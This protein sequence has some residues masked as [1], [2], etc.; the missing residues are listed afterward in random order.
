[1]LAAPVIPSVVLLFALLSSPES[2]RYYLRGGEG[3]YQPE[4]A[5]KMLLKLRGGDEGK[6]GTIGYSFLRKVSKSSLTTNRQLFAYKDMY[7]LH[8]TIE[9]EYEAMGGNYQNS[10]ERS[11]GKLG[12]LFTLRRLRNAMI[13]SSTV[14]L[15]QQLCGSECSNSKRY[16]C[17]S[18]LSLSK[19]SGN[20]LRYNSRF[21]C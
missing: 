15:A 12:R 8:K 13:S 10:K 7:L 20:L 5:L 18:N 16:G 17:I 11:P 21:S 19:R 1:M 2:P 14:S 3:K 9:E 4:K 6:V